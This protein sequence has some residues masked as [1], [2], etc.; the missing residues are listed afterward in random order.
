MAPE[1]HKGETYNELVDMW[2]FGM[3]ILELLSLKLP[4]Y[5]L[6]Y[7]EVKNHIIKGN[8][9]TLD[10]IVYPQNF[11]EFKILFENCTAFYPLDRW[12]STQ[13]LEY[14]TKL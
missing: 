10:K 4:Y 13:C 5:N 6:D 1:V 14:I 9:P 7:L 12:T 2:S 8:R 3:M 11:E